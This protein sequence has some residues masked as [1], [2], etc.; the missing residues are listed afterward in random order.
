MCPVSPDQPG[1][2]G[3]QLLGEP[4]ELRSFR[5]GQESGAL[6][7]LQNGPVLRIQMGEQVLRA[8]PVLPGLQEMLGLEHEIGLLIE[9]LQQGTAPVVEQIVDSCVI[10]A[11]GSGVDRLNDISARKRRKRLRSALR[12]N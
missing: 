9:L 5:T 2:P 11:T 6:P 7:A 8:G 3:D 1:G 12:R 4:A 10:E